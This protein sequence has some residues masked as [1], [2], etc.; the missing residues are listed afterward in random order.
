MLKTGMTAQKLL[1][2][3]LIVLF[4]PICTV[5]LGQKSEQFSFDEL[6]KEIL[7]AKWDNKKCLD[8]Y[9]KEIQKAKINENKEHLFSAYYGVL[10]YCSPEN[11]IKYSDSLITLGM[12]MGDKKAIGLAYWASSSVRLLVYQYAKALDQALIA[13]DYLKKI[14]YRDDDRILLLNIAEIRHLLGNTK[15]AKKIA[16]ECYDTY[17]RKA[18]K[19]PQK[20][21]KYYYVYSAISLIKYNASL[22]LFKQNKVILKELGAFIKRNENVADYSPSVIKADAY[23]LYCMGKYKEAIEKLD[24]AYEKYME[25]EK[26]VEKPHLYPLL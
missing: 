23:N 11:K 25:M 12:K 4:F 19:Y 14:P 2:R 8:L 7:K 20:T 18:N 21:L 13:H 3:I 6:E 10:N 16:Q 17:K 1:F 15:E 24:L 9:Q 22:H 5:V 26:G